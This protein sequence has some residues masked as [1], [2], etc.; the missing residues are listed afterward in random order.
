MA[1]AGY[2]DV[3]SVRE[4]LGQSGLTCC[5]EVVVDNPRS[6]LSER[7]DYVWTSNLTLSSP[8]LA[9]TIGDQ[10]FFRTRTRP[11]LWPSDH[12]GVAALLLF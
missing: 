5:Q 2:T 8:V 9:F 7:I 6:S 10:T 12:A 4:Q 11:R 3:W 1:G